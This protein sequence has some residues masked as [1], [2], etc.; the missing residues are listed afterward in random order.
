MSLD[1]KEL[2]D[3]L[4]I[5]TA[6]FTQNIYFPLM[7]TMYLRENKPVFFNGVF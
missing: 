5:T 4:L 3:I 7:L 1:L 2:G 6:K